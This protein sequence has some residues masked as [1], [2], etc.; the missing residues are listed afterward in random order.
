MVKTC[1]ISNEEYI[2]FV[3]D[4]NSFIADKKVIDIKYSTFT[5][6]TESWANGAL[7]ELK[8]V[9]RALVIYEGEELSGDDRWKAYLRYLV[10]WAHDH[11]DEE[12]AGMTPASFEEWC[13]NEWAASQTM[14]T[15]EDTE[16]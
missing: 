3:R 12:F 1:L 10:A 4:L 8:I 13:D 5:F 7:K 9:D 16:C 11:R 6:P 14:E 2:E 15:T